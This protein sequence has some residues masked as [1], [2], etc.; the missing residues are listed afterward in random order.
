MSGQGVAYRYAKPIMDLAL[1]KNLLEEV[2]QD[3]KL[4]AQTCDD[5]KQLAAVLRNPVIRGFKKLSILDALFS[6]KVNTL[7]FSLFSLM[8]RKNRESLLYDVSKAFVELY[9]TQKKIQK[10][11]FIASTELDDQMIQQLQTQLESQTGKYI[12]LKVKV[13][14]QLIGGY[15][16][17]IGDIRIDNSVKHAL[18]KV[19]LKFLQS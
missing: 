14:P 7:T 15:V 5:N 1:E 19:K 16:L 9:N 17:K 10:V 3:L 13:D 18:Q 2:Y 12:E 6:D 11:D 4:F 8:A